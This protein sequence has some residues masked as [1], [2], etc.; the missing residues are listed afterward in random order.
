M[1]KELAEQTIDGSVSSV[2]SFKLRLSGLEP[3][4]ARSDS[5][6][7]NVGERCNVTGSKKFL[8]L[9]KEN[10]F[11]EALAVAR[12]QVEGGAQILDINMDEGLIDG[13]SSMTKFLHLLASEPDIARI[14]VMIDSSKWEIL[15]AGLKCVQG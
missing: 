3:L 8:S 7:I 4:V 13:V 12:E 14:P 6:F 1:D 9:I 10:N 11:D 5:N 15:E 2:T